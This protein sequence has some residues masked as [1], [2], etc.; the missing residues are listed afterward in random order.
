M[1]K[2]AARDPEILDVD[3]VRAEPGS[4]LEV[5]DT[6][7]DGTTVIG[8]LRRLNPFFTEAV[9]LQEKATAT[10]ERAKARQLPTTEEE[11]LAL[12]ES[13]K[14]AGTQLKAAEAHWTITS[15]VYHL[16]KTLVAGRKRTTDPLEQAQA[17]ENKL[18]AR[19]IEE[20]RRKAAAEQERIRQENEARARADQEERARQIEQEALDREAAMDALSDREEM[21]ATLVAGGY[22]A[23]TAARQAGYKEPLKAAARLL[24]SVK[25][26]TAI[27]NKQAAAAARRQAQAVRQQ[28][29]EVEHVEVRPAISRAVGTRTQVTWGYEML[30]VKAFI[31]AVISGEYGLDPEEFLT[32]QPTAVL[33]LARARH[34]RLDEIP[35]LRHKKN[36]GVV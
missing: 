17:I 12:Q 15:T 24:N 27:D 22:D 29:V 26:K 14:D 16:H 28:P 13:I 33:N 35:G 1:A 11:D 21:F 6:A 5:V 3:E 23:N 25:I 8:F 10:L 34:E 9:A 20:A 7:K 36:T 19:Y 2:R 31:K 32:Y 18:H 4:A 30:D